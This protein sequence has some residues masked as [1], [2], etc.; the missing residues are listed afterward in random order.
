M[1]REE[2]QVRLW[3]IQQGMGLN[4][5]GGGGGSGTTA[6]S[7]QISELTSEPRGPTLPQL[8]NPTPFFTMALLYVRPGDAS[9]QHTKLI[10]N[11]WGFGC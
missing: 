3:I 9:L 7:C 2:G 6:M 1:R 10:E 5:T 4:G 11:G 8:S